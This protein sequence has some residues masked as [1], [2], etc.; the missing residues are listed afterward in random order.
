MLLPFKF[1]EASR[2][3]S[4]DKLLV[5]VNIGAK[6][7]ADKTTGMAL[8]MANAS[9]TYELSL[10]EKG[11]HVRVLESLS[12]IVD[13]PRV[14]AQI[15]SILMKIDT[16]DDVIKRAKA[17]RDKNIMEQEAFEKS[18]DIGHQTDNIIRM[19]LG[20]MQGVAK[21]QKNEV[22]VNQGTGVIEDGNIETNEEGQSSHQFKLY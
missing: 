13:Q 20:A 1:L 5:L 15:S 11:Q 22:D 6:R 4:G 3:L 2:G 19:H 8:A 9:K 7:S 10:E 16:A 18:D 17:L 21:R 12:K 14:A